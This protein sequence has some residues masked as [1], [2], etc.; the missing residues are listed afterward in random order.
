MRWMS[1]V[2]AGGLAAPGSW[3]FEQDE[4]DRPPAGFEFLWTRG[5]PG[6]RWVVRR[7]GNNRVLAWLDADRTSGRQALALVKDRSWED[8]SISVLAKSL[9]GDLDQAAGLAWRC[10]DQD[11]YYAARFSALEGD[12]GLYRVV[13]G[14]RMKLA[15]KDHLALG[16]GEWHRLGVEHRGT[17]ITVLLDGEPVIEAE[18][19][20]F[21]EA[22]RAGLWTRADSAAFFDDLRIGID[23]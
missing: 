3:S 14:H 8:L 7:D 2:L 15:G 11:N 9:S 4:V 21:R 13:D 5:I 22:G 18:D 6:G 17:S 10:Q 23:N 1:L 19:R 16:P 20:T 12:V